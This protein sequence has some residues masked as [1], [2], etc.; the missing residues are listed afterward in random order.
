[1]TDHCQP[2]T[3]ARLTF[4][5]FVKCA[6]GHGNG[7][8]SGKTSGW[9][10]GFPQNARMEKPGASLVRPAVTIHEFSDPTDANA[11]IELIDQDAVQLQSKTLRVRRVIVRLEAATVISHSVNLRARSHARVL[12]GQ[13]AYVTFGPLARG[14]ANG[15][16]VRP[17]MMLA[18]EPD[19]E[20]RFVVDAGWESM[21]FLLP[22]QDI[23]AHLT[24]RRRGREFRRPRGAEVLH[25]NPERVLALYEWGKLLVDTA[26]RQPAL[27]N[28]R[29]RE[30]VA[31]QVELVETLLATLGGASNFQPTRSDRTR[32]TRSLLVKTAEEYALSHASEPLYVTD[33]CRAAA[34]SERTL[35]YAF[36]E[37]MDLTPVAYLLRLRL[38]RVRR[39]LLAAT[40]G[41]TTVSAQ[42]LNW[43][44]WHFGEFSRAYKDC[45][46]ELPSETL[47]SGRVEPP[48]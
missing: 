11:G 7:P 4:L 2:T 41:S 39:A 47:R 42:A 30:R 19:S 43:G 9:S 29:E 26:A 38:H 37:V 31:A 17:G 28:E 46:G 8:V 32:Q 1:L 15:V 44:F 18:A 14:K 48:R 25:V 21:T 5:P 33:L 23:R 3:L 45:F 35:E 13:L 6:T 16:P 40:P 12:E 24:A 20:A 34:V 27:F 22:P 10:I 36:K